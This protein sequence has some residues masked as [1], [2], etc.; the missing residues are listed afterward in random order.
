MFVVQTKLVFDIDQTVFDRKRRIRGGLLADD[1]A[2]RELIERS[3]V[4]RD[5]TG[6]EK[7]RFGVSTTDVDGWS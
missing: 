6:S 5:L 4:D 7:C 1:E 3:A 2:A